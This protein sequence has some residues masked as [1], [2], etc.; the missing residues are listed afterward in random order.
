MEL[1]GISESDMKKIDKM[2]SYCDFPI[3]V[4]YDEIETYIKDMK[5]KHWKM[6]NTGV[7][8]SFCGNSSEYYNENLKMGACVSCFSDIRNSEIDVVHPEDHPVSK[9]MRENFVTGLIE[10]SIM[11]SMKEN[12]SMSIILNTTIVTSVDKLLKR[13]QEIQL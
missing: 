3:Y 7:K 13:D 10:N 6:K 1:P 9:K 2:M 12:I 11:L 4:N 5:E 8:C